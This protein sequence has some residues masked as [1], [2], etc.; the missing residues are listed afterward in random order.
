MAAVGLDV[1]RVVQ[2]V[3]A[4]GRE[5]ERHEGQQGVDEHV[6]VR[7][8]TCRAGRRE[9]EHVLRPLLRAGGAHQ[10][11]GTDA[12]HRGVGRGHADVGGEASHISSMVAE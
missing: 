10:A 11:P 4:A 1:G 9:H 7:E 3:G 8:D 2:V 12:L 6:T 5:A